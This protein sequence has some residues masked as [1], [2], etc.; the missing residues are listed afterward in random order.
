MPHQLLVRSLP[1][2][3]SQGGTDR[4]RGAQGECVYVFLCGDVGAGGGLVQ[5]E[6]AVW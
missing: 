2:S 4:G 5:N 1:K 3:Q 6:A